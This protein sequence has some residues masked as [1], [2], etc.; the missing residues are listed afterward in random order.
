NVDHLA[1]MAP[2][3]PYP[4]IPTNAFSPAVDHPVVGFSTNATGDLWEPT[5]DVHQTDK[6]FIVH[7]ELPGVP[8]EN[9][10]IDVQPGCLTISGEHKQSNDY[11]TSGDSNVQQRRYG[12]FRRSI[13]LP[14]NVRLDN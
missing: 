12:K 10:N 13:Q 3:P 1:T 2:V 14:A 7:I 11:K 9:I 6:T 4:L 5:I 8:R